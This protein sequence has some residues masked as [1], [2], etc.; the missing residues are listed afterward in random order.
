MNTCVIYV[1]DLSN[2]DK[3]EIDLSVRNEAYTRHFPIVWLLLN[4]IEIASQPSEVRDF[5]SEISQRDI[6]LE[7]TDESN[8]IWGKVESFLKKKRV[9]NVYLIG[10]T[11]WDAVRNLS[12][13]NYSV[14]FI[15]DQENIACPV[16]WVMKKKL[17]QDWDTFG[18]Q[19]S[20][21]IFDA[22]SPNDLLIDFEEIKNEIAWCNMYNRGIPVSRLIAIQGHIEDGW[23]PL[24]RHPADEQPE[25]VPFTP[26]VNN[27]RKYLSTKLGQNLNHVLIQYYRDGKDNIGE[28]ADK[29]LDIEKNT[30][31]INYSIGATRIMTLRKKKETLPSSSSVCSEPSMIAGVATTIDTL[32]DVT[33]TTTHHSSILNSGQEREMQRVVLRNNS[34]FLLG[35][36]TNQK[37]LHMIKPDQRP[38]HEKYPDELI[39]EQ[40]RI[41]FTFRTIATYIS[42]DKT[43]IIGQGAKAYSINEDDSEEEQDDSMAMLT[44]FSRENHLSDYTWEELYG[45]GFKTL[46]F[47]IINE[48]EQ[49]LKNEEV[50][51][52]F[53]VETKS[54]M[55]YRKLY[56]IDKEDNIIDIQRIKLILQQ[57]QISYQMITIDESYFNSF[58]H[59]QASSQQHFFVA[60]KDFYHIV[61]VDEG[62]IIQGVWKILLHILQ[63]YLIDNNDHNHHLDLVRSRQDE[64]QRY[65]IQSLAMSTD[66]L[67]SSWKSF[68]LLDKIFDSTANSS[69]TPNQVIENLMKEINF[70]QKK[71]NEFLEYL[72]HSIIPEIVSNKIEEHSFT[73]FDYAFFPIL[74]DISLS[75]QT[76]SLDRFPTLQQYYTLIHSKT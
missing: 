24:Y 46:N 35:W 66:Q 15:I 50:F 21:I 55:I 1:I 75:P 20:R 5:I 71:L 9:K 37:W 41:S 43:M 39:Y 68:K 76:F 16:K 73:L 22:V 61:F 56:Y 33:G 62:M 11:D 51:N 36:E 23:E 30:L 57:Q 13:K 8:G 14:S 69:S 29:T 28:H 49:I 19:D 17:L 32:E 38:I 42:L 52:M 59:F 63:K 26:I 54:A 10:T 31:I 74:H 25:I 67:L 48:Q 7:E 34:L 2:F 70:Q 18:E 58:K 65:H 45:K 40:G 6:I 27:L 64:Y 44:A 72:E 12:G 4:G 3:K 60:L 47:K 53:P